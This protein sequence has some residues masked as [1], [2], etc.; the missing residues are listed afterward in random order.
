MSLTSEKP[1]SSAFDKGIQ[2]GQ[3]GVSGIERRE[4]GNK[5]ENIATVHVSVSPQ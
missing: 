2:R 5:S 4:G 3:L 1:Y